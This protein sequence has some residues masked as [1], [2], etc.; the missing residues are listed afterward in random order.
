MSYSFQ[1][2][3]ANKAEAKEKV[4]LQL[5]AVVQQQVSH[6][7][8]VEQAR[9]AANAF[10][11]LVHDDESMDVSVSMNGSMGWRGT[12]G[13]EGCVF[14]SAGVGINAYLVPREAPKAD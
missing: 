14:T 9:A 2:R 4:A 8:D 12:L 1:I 10:I 7:V 3:A 5:A 6:Q 11:D 13:Q